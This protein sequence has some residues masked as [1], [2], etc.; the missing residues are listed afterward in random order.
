MK[1]SE[2]Y[3]QSSFGKDY[4]ISDDEAKYLLTVEDVKIYGEICRLEE[5]LKHSK[6]LSYLKQEK[7]KK[8]LKEYEKTFK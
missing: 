7:I 5:A 4:K 3:L 2:K 8:E 6:W 1:L